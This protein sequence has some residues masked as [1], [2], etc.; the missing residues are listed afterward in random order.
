MQPHGAWVWDKLALWAPAGGWR[1]TLREGRRA[2]M[3]DI[4][5]KISLFEVLL[6]FGWPGL[7]AGGVAG[8]ALW[9]RHRLAG[10]GI[11]AV[12]GFL[13]WAAVSLAVKLI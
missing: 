3:S 6:I 5:I 1:A 9:R 8:A 4:S 7:I 11:G 13:L 10:A 2:D 12:A